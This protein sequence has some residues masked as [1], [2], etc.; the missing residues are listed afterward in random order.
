MTP[1]KTSYPPMNMGT[2]LMLAVFLIL[3]LVVFSVLSLSGALKDSGYS[4]K[5]AL[6]TSNW[7]EASNQAEKRLA[8]IDA[9]LADNSSA[10]AQ[11]EEL[12]K[13][14]GLVL[15]TNSP[16]TNTTAGASA[17]FLISFA[18]PIDEDEI[19]QVTLSPQPQEHTHFT[20]IGWTQTSAKDWSGN[21][22]L[23]VLGSETR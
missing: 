9:I 7:Y 1:K 2:S 18:V 6:R 5:Q 15:T 22:T 23:P 3:C 12:Q 17:E 11:M 21:Q 14:E 16:K 19:L 20:I 8:V 4:E 13:L 10:A